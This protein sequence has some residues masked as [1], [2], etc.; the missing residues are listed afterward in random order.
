VSTHHAVLR[1]VDNHW[2]VKDLGSRNGTFLDGQRLRAGEGYDV[3]RD[4][5]IAFGSLLEE[6]WEVISTDAPLPM[7]MPVEGGDPVPL[8]GPLVA[9]PSPE[10]PRVTIFRLADGSFALE[11]P[12]ETTRALEN[13]QTFD[14]LGRPWRFSCPEDL[15]TVSL[16]VAVDSLETRNVELSFLVSR[17]EEHVRLL[18]HCAGRTLDLGSRNHNYLLL[19]LARS[20]LKDAGQGLP[21]AACGWVSQEELAHDPAMAPP[22]LNLDIF[23][24]RKHFGRAGVVD[25]ANLIERRPRARQFRIGTGRLTIHRE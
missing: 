21:D 5:K 20:R 2:E 8:D 4:S 16:H 6:E 3:R 12:D 11:S 1:W 13:L 15:R 24:I 23:R 7:A 17:D 14:V 22:Q 10:D 25:A 18:M 19:T 9:L